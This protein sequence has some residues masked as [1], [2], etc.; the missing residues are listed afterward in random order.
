MSTPKWIEGSP[1]HHT[2]SLDNDPAFCDMSIRF[3]GKKYSCL[4]MSFYTEFGHELSI[5]EVKENVVEMAISRTKEHLGKLTRLLDSMRMK[6]GVN[7]E[8]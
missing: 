5:D 4:A 8:P 3:D 1:G 6:K 2:C 7:H